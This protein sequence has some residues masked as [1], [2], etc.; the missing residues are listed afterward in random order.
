MPGRQDL[1]GSVVG[2]AFG[3][4]STPGLCHYSG[5]GLSDRDPTDKLTI[6]LPRE[7][8]N[9]LRS[10][11]ETTGT[12]LNTVAVDALSVGWP[13]ITLHANPGSV[14]ASRMTRPAS[15]TYDHVAFAHL[16]QRLRPRLG[17]LG[18]DVAWVRGDR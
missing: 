14:L 3:L 16:V 8:L 12:S 15:K 4:P 18:E 1:L 9:D 10:V 17:R 11:S 7:L 5:M 2:R 6:R 13:Q